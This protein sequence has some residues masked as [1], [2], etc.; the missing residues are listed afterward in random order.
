MPFIG[1]ISK[2]NDFNYIKNYFSKKIKNFELLN[3]TNNI[4]N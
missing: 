2:E 4:E 1:V 3:I